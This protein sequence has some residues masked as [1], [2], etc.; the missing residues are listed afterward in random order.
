MGTKN[1]NPSKAKT[2]LP[3]HYMTMVCATQDLNNERIYKKNETKDR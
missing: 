1:T 3:T 2:T